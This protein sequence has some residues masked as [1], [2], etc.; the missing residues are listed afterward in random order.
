MNALITGDS[1]FLGTYISKAFLNKGYKVWGISRSNSRLDISSE[2]ILP[3]QSYDVVIHCAGK[4][5]SYP[6]SIK[7]AEEFYLVNH[8]GTQN[9][10]SAL[11]NSKIK[12][13]IFISTAAIYGEYGTGYTESSN[14]VLSTPY[15]ESKFM[16]EQFLIKW[17]LQ[18]QIPVLIFRLPLIVGTNPPG[19]LG[20]MINAIKRGRYISVDKGKCKRSVVFAEDVAL[21]LTSLENPRNGL[22]NLS[23]SCNIQFS[24]FENYLC[25]VFGKK[26]IMNIDKRFISL[27]SWIGDLVPM[28]PIN[29]KIFNKLSK[30]FTV[31]SN[32]AKEELNWNPKIVKENL[33]LF[34]DISNGNSSSRR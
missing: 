7:E 14:P 11:E 10:C 21:F 5:H 29:T 16:A 4:A 31:S 12:Q 15:A 1:G 34:Y 17:G 24:D 27:F 32:L 33:N 6:K 22:Y 2:L 25:R 19:N 23:D 18:K 20:M 3:N 9:L 26:R 8:I 30:D 28:F 13:F